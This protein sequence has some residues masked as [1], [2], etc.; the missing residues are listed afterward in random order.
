[1]NSMI[2]FTQTQPGHPG[3]PLWTPPFG[4][5][6]SLER[7]FG[8][9]LVLLSSWD[10]LIN[11]IAR[12]LLINHHH[13]TITIMTLSGL[14]ALERSIERANRACDL[15]FH[16][17]QQIPL[18]EGRYGQQYYHQHDHEQGQ[19]RHQANQ[20]VQV[21]NGSVRLCPNGPG[22]ALR[23]LKAREPS[24]SFWNGATNPRFP[25]QVT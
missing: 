1:M 9:L 19:V 17:R 8:H 3:L 15:D 5:A 4:A 10:D 18:L 22:A 12:V 23:L 20:S 21:Q 7:I 16:A 24:S 14:V 2:R 13:A 25:L 6:A 11:N